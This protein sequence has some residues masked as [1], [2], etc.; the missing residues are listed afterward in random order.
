[1]DV[2]KVRQSSMSTLRGLDLL[3]RQ[4]LLFLHLVL[5][6]TRDKYLRCVL[7]SELSVARISILC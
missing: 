3:I 6:V 4:D 2:W 5:R 7:L 1:M